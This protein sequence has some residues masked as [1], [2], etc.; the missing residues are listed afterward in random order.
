MLHCE[1]AHQL[2]RYKGDAC[3]CFDMD[4][5]AE[6]EILTV[7]CHVCGH[8]NVINRASDLGY[9][10]F[11]IGREQPC[12]NEECASTVRVTFETA[13]PDYQQMICEAHGLRGEKRYMLAV[14][15]LTQAFEMFFALSVEVMLVHHLANFSDSTTDELNLL[16]DELFD[17]TKKYTY[18]RMRNLFISLALM[19]RPASVAEARELI[20]PDRISRLS[21]DPSNETLRSTD[22][23]QLA[24]LLI[25]LKTLTI[26]DLRNRVVHKRA[27]RPRLDELNEALDPATRLTGDLWVKLDLSRSLRG[28]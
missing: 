24:A 22:D 4:I 6:Y 12:Q 21:K 14:G 23:P 7:P 3:F 19:N 28:D 11:A 18:S 13:N 15:V 5:G 20:S 27:Y 25:H 10:G 9:T 1:N 26:G 2:G 17:A 8:T 16:N